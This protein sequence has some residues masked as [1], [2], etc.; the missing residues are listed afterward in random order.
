MTKEDPE[1]ARFSQ[2]PNLVDS[3]NDVRDK[4]GVATEE[5]K[6]LI[7]EQHAKKKSEYQEWLDVVTGMLNEKDS[8]A[9]AMITDYEKLKKRTV[10]AIQENPT[11]N[12]DLLGAPKIRLIALKDDMLSIEMEIVES[13]T[14]LLQEFDRN[15][16]EISE[17][18]KGQYNAYFTQVRDL[19]NN[20]FAAFS[21]NAMT[22]YEKYNQE[23]SDIEWAMW[24][25]HDYHTQKIDTLEDRLVNTELKKAND[26]ATSNVL[27]AA[28]RNRDRISEIIN[29]IERNMIELD[30]LSGEDDGMGDF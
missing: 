4:F 7:L 30:E 13:L 18:N 10:R 16:T 28:K 20:F 2:I 3:W 17:A 25:S 26:L 22:L 21:Q 9:K 29:F 5:F 14:D 12:G 8:D 15:Y 23:N 27:W 6:L 1:W 24:A 19:Q 11:E